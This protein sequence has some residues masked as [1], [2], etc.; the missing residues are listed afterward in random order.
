MKKKP[1]YDETPL[2]NFT[3]PLALRQEVPLLKNIEPNTIHSM[4]KALVRPL[5]KI[6]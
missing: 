1:Q 6:L 3:S 2:T 5:R 4:H